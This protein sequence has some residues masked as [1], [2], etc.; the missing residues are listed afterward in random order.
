MSKE[1]KKEKKIPCVAILNEQKCHC[2]FFFL[3]QNWRTWR[4]NR[5]SWR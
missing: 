4:Q 1:K 2:F 5:S 3:L